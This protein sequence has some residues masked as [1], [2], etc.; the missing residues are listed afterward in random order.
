MLELRMPHMPL[1]DTNWSPAEAEADETTA[2]LIRARGFLER[3]GH[4][5]TYARDANGNPVDPTSGAAVAWCIRGAMEAAHVGDD[6]WFPAV[7]RLSAEIGDTYN[8]CEFN[9]TQETVEPVLAAFDRAIAG[10]AA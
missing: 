6:A 5:D 8:F 1:D 2:L 4:R 7:F 3:G 10:E 9:N